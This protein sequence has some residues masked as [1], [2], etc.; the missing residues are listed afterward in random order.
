MNVPK[1]NILFQSNQHINFLRRIDKSF[2][3]LLCVIT[4]MAKF[5]YPSYTP[6]MYYCIIIIRHLNFTNYRISLV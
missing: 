1:A 5:L 4:L 3:I 2:K 6:A